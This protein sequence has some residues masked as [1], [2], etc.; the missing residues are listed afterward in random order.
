M[1][2][3]IIIS[4]CCIIVLFLFV[5]ALHGQKNTKAFSY[6]TSGSAIN[7]TPEPVLKKAGN[8]T[9]EIKG[10]I[11]DYINSVKDNWLLKAPDN[12]PALLNM[13]AV[14]DTEPYKKYLPW[15]GEFAGKYLTGA[16]MILNL[17]NDEHLKTYLQSFTDRL[18]SYQDTDGYLGP[19]IRKSRLTGWDSVSKDITWEE[20][21]HG[22]IIIGLLSWYEVTGDKRAFDC[23]CKIGDMMCNKFL[24]TKII[25]TTSKNSTE[26]NQGLIYAMTLLYEKTGRNK[27]RELAE[28]IVKEF[29][30]YDRDTLQ[31]GDYVR[32]TLA[33]KEFYQTPRP[34]WESLFSLLGIGEL[35]YI[36]GNKDYKTVLQNFWW[37][38]VKT[39]RHNNGGFSSG[40]GAMGNPYDPGYIET[41]CT[42]AWAALSVEMLE[43]TG[44]SIAAD[45]LEMSTLNQIIGYQS[46]DGLWCTY[47]TPMDGKR[48]SGS[49]A[50][51]KF[52][53]RPGSEEINCCSANAPS[54]FGT[55]GK[56]ALMSDKDGLVLNWY[57]PSV[58]K[59]KIK[60]AN[61]TLT[62]ETEYP[63]EGLIKIIVNPDV[64]KKFS[65]KL[66][67]PYWS[68]KTNVKI[69]GKK[70]NS[71][72]AG[73]YLALNRK[74]QKGD[75]II[76]EMDMSFRFWKGEKQCAGKTSVY[77]GPL[78]LALEEGLADNNDKDVSL[79]A[80]NM[81]RLAKVIK[82]TSAN[83]AQLLVSIPV[84]ERTILLRDYGT[85]GRNQTQYKTW[86]NVLNTS[87]V[88]FSKTNPGRYWKP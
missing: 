26:M 72:K 49:K 56:W 25:S 34:R 29:Q 70:I 35:Y 63:R 68:Y 24:K 81:D 14:R 31:A 77:R 50:E 41:C 9:Y 17:T 11:G 18:I 61:V 65:L 69:N 10:V 37:S 76:L 71:V 62:E 1:K 52:Q 42:V 16:S 2:S 55:I 22:H 46:P 23:A 4:I 57:G 66:R 67:V 45:E 7:R 12:N 32:Q 86:L 27:Y 28:E 21:N 60:G 43:M 44:N 53:I 54:G 51:I 20:W 5:D 13:F 79:D 74:W 30:L 6:R 83:D 87:V 39:D 15:S 78:L 59:T 47:H 3:K 40:E 73:G 36:T 85:A 80:L 33:G 48:V 88:Q 82:D 64:E 38:I 84:G 75:A 8:T 58:F 19:Y